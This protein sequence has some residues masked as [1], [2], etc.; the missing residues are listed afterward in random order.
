MKTLKLSFLAAFVALG[1]FMFSACTGGGDEP[2]TNPKLNFLAGTGYTSGD[3]SIAAGSAFKIGL[4]GSHDSKIETLKIRVSYNGGA[5]VIPDNCTICD[6]TINATDFT[7]D[8]ENMVESTP[9]TEKWSFT[10]A[11]KDGNSTTETITFTRTAAPK[12]VRSVD[13]TVGNQNSSALGSSVTLE[14]YKAYLLKDAKPISASI[15]LCY[16]L[17]DLGGSIICAPSFQ[18]AAD[19]LVG[20]NG[21]STWTTRNQTKFRKTSYTQN[22]FGAMTDSKELLA[23]AAS[24]AAT[25]DNI[26]VAVGDVIYCQPVS[27]N[28][29]ICLIMV[30]SIDTDNTM[31]VKVLAEE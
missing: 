4:V 15:D 17:D 8:Y 24:T 31:T 27:A 7:I 25:S 5:N 21:V 13:V 10:I 16:V 2:T 1:A 18:L 26:E 19:K 28:A 3:V 29:K 20:V 11:D 22:Q 6:T 30:A 12:P 23:E 9:G 14:E